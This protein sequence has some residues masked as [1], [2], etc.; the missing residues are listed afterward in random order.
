MTVIFFM[1]FRIDWQNITV[2]SY[3]LILNSI[4][5]LHKSWKNVD[6]SMVTWQNC[7]YDYDKLNDVS[8]SEDVL[9]PNLIYS[10]F[11]LAKNQVKLWKIIMHIIFEIVIDNLYIFRCTTCYSRRVFRPGN[12]HHNM[13]LDLMHISGYMD[14]HWSSSTLSLVPIRYKYIDNFVLLLPTEK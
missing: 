12:M 9:H 11:L 1:L 4:L 14:C 6:D 7:V 3:N 2:I 10:N 5:N 8:Q 13:P